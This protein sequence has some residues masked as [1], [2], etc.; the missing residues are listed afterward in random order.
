MKIEE[1]VLKNRSYRRFDE[2]DPI[3]SA[4]LVELVDLTRRCP[5]T[6]N[7]QPM[8][9]MTISASSEREAIFPHLRWAAYIKEW[10]GPAPGE[11]PTGYIVFLD[12]TSISQ[13]AGVDPGVCG[14]TMLLRA[15]E[16][17]FGGC[18]IANLNK[19]GL[20]QVLNIPETMEILLVI[21]FG[22]PAEEVL[23][24]DTDESGSI[25]YYRD[26]TDRHHVPK[27]PL[28]EILINR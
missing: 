15:V 5:S 10:D 22:R 23:L 18:M 27:R 13:S 24:E 6:A 26:K 14:Q 21:A 20:R 4:L 2:S 1:L 8:K 25:R 16:A 28:N 12:D 11:R 7:R 3:P 19:E 17:G 9:F